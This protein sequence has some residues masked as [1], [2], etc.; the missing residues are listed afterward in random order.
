MIT[1]Q[2]FEKELEKNIVELY[3]KGKTQKEISESLGVSVYIVRK[4]LK[5]NNITRRSKISTKQ[6]EFLLEL[7]RDIFELKDEFRVKNKILS[8]DE[9]IVK[10]MIITLKKYKNL[11][12]ELIK[13]K[14]RLKYY[15]KVFGGKLRDG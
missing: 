4:F 3:H 8:L 10:A 6:A 13:T 15:E 2:E 1:K 14:N 9:K 12:K 11:K 5:K 7:M